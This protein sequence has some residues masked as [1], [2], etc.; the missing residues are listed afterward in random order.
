MSAMCCHFCSKLVDTDF[1][2]DSLL[3]HDGECVCKGC[4]DERNL[5][6]EFDGDDE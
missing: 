6:T 4:C 2:P 3:E 1:D 5:K